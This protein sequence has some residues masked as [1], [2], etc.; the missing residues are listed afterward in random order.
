MSDGFERPISRDEIMS[1]YLAELSKDGKNAD[2][3][4]PYI[5]G[6]TIEENGNTYLYN[7]LVAAY[8]GQEE[9]NKLIG[10]LTEQDKQAAQILSRFLPILRGVDMNDATSWFGKFVPVNVFSDY[11][12]DGGWGNR[13]MHNTAVFGTRLLNPESNLV[14][15]GLYNSAMGMA[16]GAGVRAYNYLQSVRMLSDMLNLSALANDD[17]RYSRGFRMDLDENEKAQL[18]EAI[19]MSEELRQLIS[20]KIGANNFKSYMLAISDAL[21]KDTGAVAKTWFGELFQKVTRTASAM[22]LSLKPRQIFTNL[23][24]NYE[25]MGGL[26]SHN[27]LWYNT[28][29]LA[30]AAAHAKEA[31][32]S[33]KSN[34]AFMHRL[35]QSALS[36]QYRRAADMKADSILQDIE[37][38]ALK[39][40]ATGTAGAIG[41]ADALA[42]VMTKYSIGATNTLPDMVGLALGRWVV[43]EDVKARIAAQAAADG[44][45]MSEKQID[46][47]AENQIADYMFSH[48]SSSNI[49]ARGHISKEFARHG[50]EGVAAFKNDQLQ[51]TAALS[52]AVTRLMNNPK[53]EAVRTQAWHEIWG[54]VLSD[55]AYVAI[56]AGLI[57]ALYKTLT[58]DDMSDKEIEYLVHSSIRELIAQVA[59][60]FNGSAFTQPVLEAFFL[61]K[62]GGLDFLPF[63]E[64]KRVARN[65]KKGNWWEVGATT[66]GL[67]GFSP[68]ERAVQIIRAL[69]M[70][71]GDDERAAQVGWMMIAGRSESTAKNMLGYTTNKAGKIVPKKTKKKKD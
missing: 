34:G 61:G 24:G 25:V 36:E 46:I 12:Q 43:L 35:E 22:A 67:L 44:R 40:G 62:E 47:E 29:G 39:K 41:T 20:D 68:T 1:L 32:E 9:F 59:D 69:S 19:K 37:K 58:G 18:N 8:G 56:Q 11:T 64:F 5:Y 50:F 10:V 17:V 57:R 16:G 48:I 66:T 3:K 55:V 42:K 4:I 60:A 27:I 23:S 63:P 54:I 7:K 31:W 33:M 26:S 38:L 21:S 53:N 51:K 45:K 30:D 28:V 65:A 71:F 52:N 15:V 70:V 14:A 2:F 6:G 49:M 13:R